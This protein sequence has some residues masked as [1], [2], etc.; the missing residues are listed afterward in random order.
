ME[1]KKKIDLALT[2]AILAFLLMQITPL[3]Y[4]KDF[5]YFKDTISGMGA[6]IIDGEFNFVT[7]TMVIISHMLL[8][9]AFFLFTQ[10]TSEIYRATLPHR[11]TTN[12]IM[13][14][15]SGLGLFLLFIAILT[16]R[17]VPEPLGYIHRGS[18]LLAFISLPL[19]MIMGFLLSIELRGWKSSHTYI[20]IIFGSSFAIL[21][22]IVINCVDSQ[23]LPNF[24]LV[25]AGQKIG[26]N[27]FLSCL[28]ILL[29]LMKFSEEQ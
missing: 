27:L 26:Y 20:P 23:C 28:I 3:F 1:L 8:W 12:K 14:F 9:A 4:P 24:N 29:S 21:T 10:T 22:P 13:V 18:A 11:S 25:P 16:P 17:G 15:F 19:S 6:I 5:H 2:S 7:S